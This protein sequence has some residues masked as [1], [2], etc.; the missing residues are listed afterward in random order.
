MQGSSITSTINSVLSEDGKSLTFKSVQHSDGGQYM[1]VAKNQEGEDKATF[2]IKVKSKFHFYKNTNQLHLEHAV[3]RNLI[4]A[5]GLNDPPLNRLQLFYNL[6]VIVNDHII[7]SYISDL[8]HV[9]VFYV[10]QNYGCNKKR[11]SSVDNDW[12]D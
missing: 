2:R 5:T 6:Q 11:P 4:F 8:S 3:L 9:P 10:W 7:Y 12:I 1:C